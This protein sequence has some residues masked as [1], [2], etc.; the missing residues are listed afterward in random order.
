MYPTSHTEQSHN[1]K[2]NINTNYT[3][4]GNSLCF[5]W[6]VGGHFR[7]QPTRHTVKLLCFEDT[8]NIPFLCDYTTNWIHIQDHSFY[9]ILDF[10][11][12]Q[13]LLL[14][15]LL[16]EMTDS[17]S[18]VKDIY[19]EPQTISHSRQ[20]GSHQT[21]KAYTRGCLWEAVMIWGQKI[22]RMKKRSLSVSQIVFSI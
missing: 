1:K 17:R 22:P 10:Q 12:F 16:G 18:E 8:Q 14:L 9:F 3:A 20:Q 19:D 15:G 6:G 5:F 2:T 11:R 21:Q 13:N 4:T 7:I